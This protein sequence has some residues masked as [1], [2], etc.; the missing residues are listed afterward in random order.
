MCTNFQTN[1]VAFP[2]WKLELEPKSLNLEHFQVRLT[3]TAARIGKRLQ[4]EAEGGHH[5]LNALEIWSVLARSDRAQHVSKFMALCGG[6][7]SRRLFCVADLPVVNWNVYS[8]NLE[9]V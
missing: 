6:N 8:A 1:L 3:K 2:T 5:T 9:S 4:F 7:L